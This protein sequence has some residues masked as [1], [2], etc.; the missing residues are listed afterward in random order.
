[1]IVQHTEDPL[2]FTREQVGGK[3]FN[4]L[5]LSKFS[6]ESGL[7]RV[8][9]YFVIVPGTKSWHCGDGTGGYIKYEDDGEIE[10]AFEKLSKPVI[11]RS[12]SV[13]EDGENASFAGMFVS[14]PNNN[15]FKEFTHSASRV[16]DSSFDED[17]RNYAEKMGIDF[18]CSMAMI[19]QEQVMDH[20]R[21]GTIQLEEEK[22]IIEHFGKKE[23]RPDIFEIDY[24]FLDNECPERTMPPL[25]YIAG[26]HDY[27]LM[28]LARDAKKA[29]GLE[30]VVQ[31]EFCL[32]PKR[33]PDF[34]QIRKLPKIT[35]LTT[36]LNLDVPE[37]VPKL[38]S[39][40]C[41]GVAGD[42]S[43]PAY[44]TV[45]PF[46]LTGILVPTGQAFY[47]GLGA[48]REG[49][50]RA[51]QFEAKSKLANNYDFVQ[52]RK[53]KQVQRYDEHGAFQAYDQIWRKG[54]G[55]F[56]NYILV[57]DRLDESCD[58]MNKLT[59]N[60]RAIIT[61]GDEQ[62]TSHAMTVARELGIMCMGVNGEFAE[63]D[64]FMHQVETGD[65][66]R[67]KSDG[68]KAVAYVEKRRER[69]PYKTK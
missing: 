41:N 65:L 58:G 45:S 49:D 8:P 42:I 11:V 3:G 27:L 32:S 20:L 12:S 40:I 54:N 6:R 10:S 31:V 21:R 59:T 61:C 53:L 17:V 7:F 28:N 50:D 26:G 68:K 13:D 64:Y 16:Y 62:K 46:G 39:R 63:L 67:M 19:V 51:E 22:A 18:S 56:K 1:M 55:L 66:I 69:D 48:P 5:R 37:G 57:C 25:D 52:I 15:T 36:E 4:L 24:G 9:P 23:V 43:L 34:V 14:V 47:L 30:G 44:V 29:L 60:K 33:L 38:E 35:A 2:K